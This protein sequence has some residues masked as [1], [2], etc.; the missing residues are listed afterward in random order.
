MIPLSWIPGSWKWYRPGTLRFSDKALKSKYHRRLGNT[1]RTIRLS[2]VPAQHLPRCSVCLMSN[3]LFTKIFPSQI[4]AINNKHPR[5]RSTQTRHST[6]SEGKI[7][8]HHRL[9][10]SVSLRPVHFATIY[11]RSA[12]S[13]VLPPGV[14]DRRLNLLKR[15]SVRASKPPH[16]VPSVAI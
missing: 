6:T 4:T 2:V 14:S 7:I 15:R 1:P 5:R 3:M 11:G 8:N 12:Y 10:N 13:Q 9:C 16:L